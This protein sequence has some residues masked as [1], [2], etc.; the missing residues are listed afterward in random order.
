MSQKRARVVTVTDSEGL[1][2]SIDTASPTLNKRDRQA[3]V[4]MEDGQQLLVPI[5]EFRKQED[6]SFTALQPAT[7]RERPAI[8]PRRPR[9]R[10]RAG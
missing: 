5:D 7:T 1:R 3:L 8:G 4:Y 9:S 10:G 6:G 2:G